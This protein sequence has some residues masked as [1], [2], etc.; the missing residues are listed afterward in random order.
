MDAFVLPSLFGEGL[1]MVILESM[2]SGTPVI[3]AE[4]ERVNQ[5]IRIGTD[6]WIFQPGDATAPANYVI[7][8]IEK[9][10]VWQDFRASGLPRQR[11]L[12]SDISMAEEVAAVYRN[13][14]SERSAKY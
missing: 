7:D 10:Y 8:L 5:A 9:K 12:F 14:L 3:V 6:G 11:T 1:S 13:L 2:A 4:V